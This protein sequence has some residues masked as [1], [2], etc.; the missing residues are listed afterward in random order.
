MSTNTCP[1][2]G[3]GFTSRRPEAV[4][5]SPECYRR[6]YDAALSLADLEARGRVY[7]AGVQRRTRCPY[8]GDEPHRSNPNTLLS[9]NIET[10]AYQCKS[11]GVAG[12]L[13]EHWAQPREDDSAGRTRRQRRPRPPIAPPPSRLPTP[14][15]L[16]DEA[17]RRQRAARLWGESLPLDSADAAPG[18]AYLQGRGIPLPVAIAAGVRYHPRYPDWVGDVAHYHG[19]IVFRVQGADGAGVAVETRFLK[20]RPDSAKSKSSGTK[21]AGVFVA[22][23]GALDV[24]GLTIAEGPFTALSIAACGFA[25]VAL[26]GRT[27]PAWLPTRLA[28]RAVVIAF[29]EGETGCEEKAAALVRELSA[30]GARPY[31]LRLPAGVDVNDRLRTAGLPALRAELD[32]AICGALVPE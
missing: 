30:V 12:R 29:D 1:V 3:K 28:L 9:V 19:A 7:G 10:G 13:R 4:Y 5:C 23:P 2:C 27:A 11:C 22:S 24:D 26:C 8:C 25:C 14:A 32:A 21:G 31:R 16:A 17:R 6:A 15:A 18:A 20:P